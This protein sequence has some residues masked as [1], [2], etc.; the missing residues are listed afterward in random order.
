MAREEIALPYSLANKWDENNAH[1][2]RTSNQLTCNF[3]DFHTKNNLHPP[4]QHQHAA[5][6]V[7]ALWKVFFGDRHQQR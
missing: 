3:P 7:M 6:A 2:P 5:E 1:C 4:V